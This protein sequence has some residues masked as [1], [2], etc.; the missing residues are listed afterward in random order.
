[1]QISFKLSF[2][3]F[4][5]KAHES[6]EELK[7]YAKFVSCLWSCPFIWKIWTNTKSLI[8]ATN[9]VTLEVNAGNTKDTHQHLVSGV[10]NM[11]KM[12][13][14][15]E[16]CGKRNTVQLFGRVKEIWS[17]RKW[18]EGNAYCPSFQYPLSSLLKS[19]IAVNGS[20]ILL[21]ILYELK[22]DAI[23]GTRQ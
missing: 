4:I 15:L 11:L 18:W 14:Y 21:L 2:R 3:T 8:G 9:E 17:P 20:L 22:L 23:Q 13:R 6:K 5:I 10:Q 1:M 7:M 19:R 12:W 16:N